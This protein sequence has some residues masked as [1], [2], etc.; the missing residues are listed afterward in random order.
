MS[1]LPSM[2]AI[3]TFA[4]TGSVTCAIAYDLSKS[5][6]LRL[7]GDSRSFPGRRLCDADFRRSCRHACLGK[8][9]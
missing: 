1:R 5:T 9:Q 2:G 8:G 3:A 6:K 7:R 4:L